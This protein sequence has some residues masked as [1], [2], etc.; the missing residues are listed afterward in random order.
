MTAL[1]SVLLAAAATV[2]IASAAQAADPIM[3]VPVAP[4]VPVASAFDWNGFYAGARVGAENKVQ[5]DTDWTLG[6]EIGV[7]AAFDMFVLGGEVG[8]DYVFANADYAYAEATL[9]AGVLVAPEALLYG[10]V[11]YGSDLDSTANVGSGNHILAGLGAEFAVTDS[12]SLDARY[13]YGWEQSNDAGTSDIHKFTLG[14][15]FHF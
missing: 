11:G 9:R 1:K 15:N 7:N 2:A 14:A 3:P 13:V 8:I 6:V 5:S 12:V 4:I 10:T